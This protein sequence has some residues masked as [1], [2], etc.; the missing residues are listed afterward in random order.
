MRT[1]DVS[2]IKTLNERAEAVPDAVYVVDIDDRALS[3]GET[4]D[5]IGLWAGAYRR[6]GVVAGEHVV[7]MQLNTI[8]S[9]LG[10]LGLAALRAVE[11]P[12]NIDYRGALLAH[13]LNLTRARI[14]VVLERYAERLIPIADDLETLEQVIVLDADKPPALPFEVSSGAELLRE[15]E[16][17]SALRTPAPWDIMAILFTSGTTGRS[18][19]VRLPWAQIHAMTTGSFPLEDLGPED[20]IYNP[21]PTYHVGAKVRPYMAALVGGRHVMRPYISASAQSK[22]YLKYGVTTGGPVTAWLTEPPHPDDRDRPLRNVL[23]PYKLPYVDEF[24]QRFGCRRSGCFNMTEVSCPIRF[25]G[26]DA[27][28]YDDEGRMSCGVIRDGY[29]ARVVDGH[30]QPVEPG[31]VG[32]LILRSDV[33]WSLNAGYLNNPEAT[34]EAWRNGWFH[35]GDAVICD[36]DGNYYFIDR[37]KDCIRRRGENISSFEVEAYAA[38]HPAIAEAAAVAVKS[39][40]EPGANEEIKLVVVL[41]EDETL[42]PA[43]LI[44]WLIPRMPRFMIPRYVELVDELPR[45]PTLKVRKKVL[46]DAAL[47]EHTWDREAAGIEL[48]RLLH[49][50]TAGTAAPSG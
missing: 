9:M 20:V 25:R 39:S 46:R 12:I 41:A 18:K 30:D 47:N 37:T 42:D 16:P 28:V 26:W 14:M 21:G 10:W 27:V 31:V 13:A 40:A 36:A 4:V 24:I 1:P 43:E 17:V 50:V 7:T 22:E 32:E 23:A 19:A 5:Q 35:T 44:A 2:L 15:V 45:T 34:A 6:F 8:E 29:E 38:E 48:P 33:P 11:A 3:Y 49:P